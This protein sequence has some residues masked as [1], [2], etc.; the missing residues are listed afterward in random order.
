MLVS[1]L[2][3]T[4]LSIDRKDMSYIVQVS[5]SIRKINRLLGAPSPEVCRRIEGW[6]GDW[7]LFFM[8]RTSTNSVRTVC[9]TGASS[10]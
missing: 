8:E 5:G 1:V 9:N 2:L 3:G 4:Q 6:K 10:G 7:K